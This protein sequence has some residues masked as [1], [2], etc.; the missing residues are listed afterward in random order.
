MASGYY[1]ERYSRP[2]HTLE[3]DITV[4]PDCAIFAINLTTKAEDNSKAIACAQ[5]VCNKIE[6][7]VQ[8][9]FTEI[10]LV[11]DSYQEQHKTKVSSKVFNKKD[12]DYLQTD[13]ALHLR[14][15]MPEQDFWQRTQKISRIL[16][17]LKNIT[18]E[19]KDSDNIDIVTH[20]PSFHVSTREKYRKQLSQTI[21]EKMMV[22]INTIAKEQQTTAKVQ[23]VNFSPDIQCDIVNISKAVLSM[24]LNFLITFDK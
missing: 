6:K 24:K 12:S 3:G 7:E 19:Y 21:Y 18:A 10:T 5:E 22:T 11:T 4:I 17:F 15:P 23:E 8:Q 14:V 1:K 9:L 16:D 13:I 2:I 20:N